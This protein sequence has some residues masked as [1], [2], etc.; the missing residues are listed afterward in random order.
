MASLLADTWRKQNKVAGRSSDP[1]SP[2]PMEVEGRRLVGKPHD[3]SHRK[4]H[5][6]TPTP[7]WQHTPRT[8]LPGQTA[9][10]LPVGRVR[11]QQAVGEPHCF[12]VS[13]Q[14]CTKTGNPH[15]EKF[16]L[17]FAMFN[18]KIPDDHMKV[19]LFLETT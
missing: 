5:S 11:G 7:W 12:P 8:A 4:P 15:F 16:E 18:Q 6:V 19:T 14:L 17:C 10:P 1:F 3:S 2:S 13:L 9:A